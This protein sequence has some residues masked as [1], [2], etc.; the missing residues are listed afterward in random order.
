MAQKTGPH[1]LIATNDKSLSKKAL[2]LHFQ[3]LL[4]SLRTTV[5]AYNSA[6]L[7]QQL[8]INNVDDQGGPAHPHNSIFSNQFKR[9]TRVKSRVF[10]LKVATSGPHLNFFLSVMQ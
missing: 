10:V 8:T 4:A 5:H 1:N 9:I 7:Q 6:R 3:F 2:F